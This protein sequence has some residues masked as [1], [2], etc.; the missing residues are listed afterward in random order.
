MNGGVISGGSLPAGVTLGSGS[1]YVNAV[2][3]DGGGMFTMNSGEI[4]GRNVTAVYIGSAPLYLYATGVDVMSGTFTMNGGEIFGN[5][6]IFTSDVSSDTIPCYIRGGGVGL[7]SSSSTFTMN[8]G[9]I[10]GNSVRAIKVNK[11]TSLVYG[12]G[13]VISGNS[14]TNVGGGVNVAS[15]G[16]FAKTGGTIYGYD[17]GD[18]ENSNAV[19]SSASA[20]QNDKGHAVY[21]SATYHKET[22]LGPDDQLF[23]NYPE[24]GNISGSW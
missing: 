23:Y 19:K 20:I 3:V 5:S 14:T 4:T 7:S 17:S 2:V 15:S 18:T 1:Y 10:S 16:T 24:T 9:K 12:G 8:N 21:V 22:T 6:L 11:G 13:G